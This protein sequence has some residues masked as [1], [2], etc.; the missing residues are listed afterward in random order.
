MPGVIPGAGLTKRDE[1][2][3]TA[4]PDIFTTFLKVACGLQAMDLY[5]MYVAIPAPFPRTPKQKHMDA[6][7]ACLTPIALSAMLRVQD[8]IIRASRK[9]TILLMMNDVLSLGTTDVVYMAAAK[10]CGV[11]LRDARASDVSRGPLTRFTEPNRQVPINTAELDLIR[12]IRSSS[13]NKRTRL[14]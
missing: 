1:A 13:S 12:E 6:Y 4:M 9:T 3:L 5:K 14:T 10:L 7:L 2:T 11:Y 8:L